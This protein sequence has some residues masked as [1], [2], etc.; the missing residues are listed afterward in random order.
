MR[1]TYAELFSFSGANY[2]R[3]HCLRPCFQDLPIPESRRQQYPFLR[4][5]MMVSLHVFDITMRGFVCTDSIKN[6]V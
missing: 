1:L 4:N 6:A 2:A 3:V 5:I